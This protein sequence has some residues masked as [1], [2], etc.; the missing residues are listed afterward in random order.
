MQLPK[1][2]PRGVAAFWRSNLV[3]WWKEAITCARNVD[4]DG[5]MAAIQ[6]NI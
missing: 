3:G 1:K 4:Y 5:L 2:N 6:A